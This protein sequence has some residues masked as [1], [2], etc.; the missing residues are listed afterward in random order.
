MPAKVYANEK[1][2]DSI[3]DISGF[4]WTLTTAVRLDGNSITRIESNSFGALENLEELWLNN[5]AGPN[6]SLI[7]ESNAFS[8]LTE[9]VKLKLEDNG[10]NGTE[11][12]AFSGLVKLKELH[13]NSNEI[14][15]LGSVDFSGVGDPSGLALY[16]QYNGISSIESSDFS[17]LQQN[18]RELWLGNNEISSI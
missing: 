1:S 18:L 17:E 10:I 7:I 9:L 5:N 6:E 14:S 8:G 2:I 13:L 11:S 3:G 16:L 15:S 12:N 4:D